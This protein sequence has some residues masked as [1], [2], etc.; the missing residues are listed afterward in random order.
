MQEKL[1]LEERKRF[2]IHLSFIIFF[3]ILNW[4]IF[5]I[6]SS[7]VT[8]FHLQLGHSL[9]IVENWNFDQGWEITSLVKVISFFVIIKFISIR[10]TSRK[11]M[12]TFF[13]DHYKNV[14]SPLFTL[15]IFNLV[16]AIIFLRPVIAQRVTFELFKVFSSYL[17]SIIFIFSEV[18]FLLFLQN[19][20]KVSSK[21]KIIETVLFVILSYLVNVNVFTH[22]QYSLS[23]LPFFLLLCFSSSYWS[24]GSWSYPLLV[25]VIFIGPLISLLGIDFIWGNEFSY[26]I[27]SSDPG[28]LL[29]TSLLCVSLGY[30][31]FCR[32]K[33]SDS[34]DQ[35]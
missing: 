14:S 2:L 30:M 25:L 7:V 20:Y 11:P 17:G 3:F 5:L 24:K 29:F 22:S 10:S 35:V 32:R 6:V 12:R 16:F 33:K 34:L 21:K 28:P 8:F 18:I 31:Y 9:N 13:I 1:A 4:A 23:S 15:I 27:S 26:L 19:V